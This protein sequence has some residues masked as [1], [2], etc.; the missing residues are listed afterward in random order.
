MSW[1]RCPRCAS[2]CII[3]DTRPCM[4]Y[5][6]RRVL[7][8]GSQRHR[9]TTIE[10]VTPRWISPEEVAALFRSLPLLARTLQPLI[11]LLKG[12]E[13]WQKKK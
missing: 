1:P 11:T 10:L 13:P 3:T 4:G 8:S 5:V 7:C 12:L 9:F 2:P 6:R